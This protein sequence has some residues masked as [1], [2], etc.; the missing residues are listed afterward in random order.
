[1]DWRRVWPRGLCHRLVTAS[2]VAP[3]D[4]DA[5]SQTPRERPISVDSRRG[6]YSPSLFTVVF[7]GFSLVR[8]CRR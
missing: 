3:D 5:P 7:P 4:D 2:G 8:W 1:M 6:S